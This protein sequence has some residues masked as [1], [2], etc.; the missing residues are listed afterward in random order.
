MEYWL[1]V[2]RVV[3]LVLLLL[4]SAE[5]LASD[6]IASPECLFSSRATHDSADG[7]SG[8]GCLCCCTHIVVVQPIVPLARL[9]LVGE[10]VVVRDSNTPDVPPNRIEH[11]PRS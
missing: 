11:P 3:T 1:T 10:T 2:R 6:A 4:A 7:C 9:G 8:D 5:I